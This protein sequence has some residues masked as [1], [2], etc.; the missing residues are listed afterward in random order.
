MKNA[1]IIIA[2]TL[3][4]VFNILLLYINVKQQNQLE[5]LQAQIKPSESQTTIMLD[6]GIRLSSD[7]KVPSGLSLLVFFT[8][9]SCLSC[10]KYEAQKLNKFY[11]NYGEYTQVY[12]LSTYKSYLERF[13]IDFKYTMIN[14]DKDILNKEFV[15]ANPVALL[16]DSNGL[17]QRFYLAEAGNEA[18]SNQFYQQMSSLFQSIQHN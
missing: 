13:D 6:S 8:D 2:I 12:L 9:R 10:L 14:P 17:V 15:F 16:V 3:L 18:K 7:I 1:K 11:S 4:T 5:R